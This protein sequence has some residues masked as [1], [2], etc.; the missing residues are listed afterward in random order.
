MKP[1]FAG[2]PRCSIRTVL[3]LLNESLPG[4]SGKIMFCLVA[5]TCNEYEAVVRG[6]T[7]LVETE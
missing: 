4:R 2:P 6:R 5:S 7:F 3:V 1:D